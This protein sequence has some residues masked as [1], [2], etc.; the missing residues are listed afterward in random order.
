MVAPLSGQVNHALDS[1]L[2]LFNLNDKTLLKVRWIHVTEQP[3]DLI[4]LP[5]N[6][7][8]WIDD[9]MEKI[10]FILHVVFKVSVC[11]VVRQW[12][13]I[14]LFLAEEGQVQHS[15]EEVRL[16]LGELPNCI[17]DGHQIE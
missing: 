1:S 3:L 4:D 10:R 5:L 11:S 9:G 6:N 2:C 13:R 8:H 16:C 14:L 12:A 7:G 17:F 15:T